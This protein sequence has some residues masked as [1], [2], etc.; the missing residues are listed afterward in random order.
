[1]K[2]FRKTVTKISAARGVAPGAA[3]TKLEEEIEE[4]YDA[5][6]GF[7]ESL[8]ASAK[9]K[10]LAEG[11]LKRLE[12]QIKQIEKAKTSLEIQNNR[13]KKEIA[14]YSNLRTRG[15]TD[16]AILRWE[17]IVS[18]SNLAPGD[19][20]AEL[21]NVGNLSKIEA[22]I[23]AR[24]DEEKREAGRV[25]ANNEKLRNQYLRDW[26]SVMKYES[27]RK[28]GVDGKAIQNWAKLVIEAGLEPD[29]LEEGLLGLKALDRTQKQIKTLRNE[30]KELEARKLKLENLVGDIIQESKKSMQNIADNAVEKTE[31]VATETKQELEKF[32]TEAQSGLSTS[33]ED[34]QSKVDGATKAVQDKSDEIKGQLQ[35][36]KDEAEKMLAETE[37][38]GERIARLE[39]IASAYEFIS[40]GKG[41]L[42][43][44][45]IFPVA[46]HFMEKLKEWED[47]RSRSLEGPSF[48][49]G[50]LED[51]IEELEGNWASWRDFKRE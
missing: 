19:I 44:K 1:M 22:K 4:K 49:T 40:E 8:K 24:I 15:V 27:L 51:A 25:A 6:L 12:E 50:Q 3:M 2:G 21:V 45:D 36:M 38:A 46:T 23:K 17:R 37:E 13:K 32:S 14:A 42:A 16:S 47:R 48:E 35:E 43:E 30:V 28:R 34:L 20:Q 18:A 31:G 10:E 39:P 26:D 7:E 29:T 5:V 41:K 9:D 33:I 11:E